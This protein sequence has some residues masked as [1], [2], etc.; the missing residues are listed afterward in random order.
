MTIWENAMQ[1]QLLINSVLRWT[2]RRKSSLFITGDRRGRRE[3][4]E[5]S[6]QICHGANADSAFAEDEGRIHPKH[7][8]NVC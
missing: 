8:R 3:I 4:A 5:A 2:A 7:G 1:Y 6:R